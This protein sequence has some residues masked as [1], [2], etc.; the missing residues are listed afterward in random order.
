MDQ[1]LQTFVVMC[2]LAGLQVHLVDGKILGPNGEIEAVGDGEQ[3][4]C[5]SQLSTWGV[6]RRAE[7][8]LFRPE[9]L[10]A[11]CAA[12]VNIGLAKLP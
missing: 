7:V 9:N 6:V 2:R 5:R 4:L 10:E 3:L 11:G 8:T 12:V 1:A